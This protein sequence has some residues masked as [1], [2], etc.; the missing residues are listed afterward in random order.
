MLTIPKCYSALVASGNG[1]KCNE[2]KN[3]INSILLTKENNTG[4]LKVIVFKYYKEQFPDIA[5]LISN[6]LKKSINEVVNDID[7]IYF[8]NDLSKRKTISK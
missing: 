2:L 1:A 6:E 4:L 8:G 5:K 7:D 3:K